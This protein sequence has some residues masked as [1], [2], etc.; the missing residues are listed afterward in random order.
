MPILRDTADEEEK[1]ARRRVDLKTLENWDSGASSLL[2][3]VQEVI[4]R[5]GQ[6]IFNR[7]PGLS[8]GKKRPKEPARCR[9]KLWLNMY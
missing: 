7:R 4:T 6:I 9:N 3:I 1:V 5:K 8:W 2:H